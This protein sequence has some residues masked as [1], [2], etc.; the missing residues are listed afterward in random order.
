MAHSTSSTG[1]RWRPSPRRLCGGCQIHVLDRRAFRAVE[2]GVAVLVALRR[3]GEG[4]GAGS[5]PVPGETR[6]EWRKP[7]YEYEER[8]MPVDILAGSP[9][10]RRQIEAGVDAR[11]IAASWSQSVAA[12]EVVRRNYLRY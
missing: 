8:L 2:T 6:F 11:E 1:A 5:G 7:P 4:A 12:F 10:L 3:E 9:A